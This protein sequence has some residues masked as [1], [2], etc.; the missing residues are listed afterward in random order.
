MPTPELASDVEVRLAL[1]LLG[2][3]RALVSPVFHGLERIPRSRPLLFVGN[4]TLYGVLDIPFLFAELYEREGIFLRGLGDR[5]HF[6]VPGWRELLAHFGVVVGD[7]EACGRLLDAG[8]CV[9]VFPGGARE[10]CRRRGEEH[11]LIWKQ[12]IGFAKMA[13]Q[14]R[15]TIVPFAMVGIDD[16]FDIA[17]D[18]D[19]LLGSPLGPLLEDL[20][21]RQDV[22]PPLARRVRPNRLYFHVGEPIAVEGFAGRSDDEAAWELR[23]QTAAAIEAG[24]EFLLQA[25]ARDPEREFGARVR[26]ALRGLRFLVDG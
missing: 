11:K 19:D 3:M 13:L 12:R 17:Y 5:L 4:H 22:I 20:K 23:E 7:R 6:E 2:P 16:A 14:H 21:I 18:A 9:L 10:V 24:I 26:R 8:E 1:S 15:A 25:R